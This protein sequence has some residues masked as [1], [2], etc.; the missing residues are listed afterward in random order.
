MKK[1]LSISFVILCCGVFLIISPVSATSGACSYHGGVN[2]SAGAD[3]DGSV[4]CN[5]G[6][7]D[8]DVL[9]S[10]MSACLSV[11]PKYLP[12]AD[13]DHLKQEIEDSIE[14]VKSSY[15]KLCLDAF[16]RSEILNDQLYQSCVRARQSIE[17]SRMRRGD[18][19]PIENPTQCEDER[20]RRTEV[21]KN[22]QDVCNGQSTDTVVKY[23][24]MLVCLRVEKPIQ[25]NV[26]GQANATEYTPPTVPTSTDDC[27]DGFTKIDNECVSRDELCHNKLGDHSFSKIFVKGLYVCECESGY[28][29]N[30]EKTQ[31]VSI[32]QPVNAV[33][34]PAVNSKANDSS[35]G[36]TFDEFIKINGITKIQPK[37]SSSESTDEQEK[38]TLTGVLA[39]KLAAPPPPTVVEPTT[40]EPVKETPKPF[41]VRA[42]SF[43]LK[44]FGVAKYPRE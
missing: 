42:W 13:Y 38:V 29:K 21:S 27:L 5:D 24:E 18:N 44:I 20:M 25:N 6:W 14:K 1:I 32:N 39:P 9:Y 15:Q 26:S 34:A 19:T 16:N 43:I 30:V 2:C 22:Q 4:I 12:Q 28:T 23:T 35:K 31:C 11:C 10:S 17:T 33:V 40:K 41:Y 8:S 7:K 36:L 3:W 37:I